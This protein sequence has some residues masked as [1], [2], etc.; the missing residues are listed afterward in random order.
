M[1]SNQDHHKIIEQLKQLPKI[2]DHTDKNDLYEQIRM[3]MNRSS[4]FTSIPKPTKKNKLIPLFSLALVVV[5]VLIM[6]PSFINQTS[7]QMSEKRSN[8]SIEL[9]DTQENGNTSSLNMQ[10]S[11]EE[12]LSKANQLD[13]HKQSYVLD[14]VGENRTI[15]YGAIVEEQ[16][17]FVIP[18]SL[19]LNEESDLSTAYNELH[20]YL[21][22]EEWGV[23]SDLFS[24]VTF[25]IDLSNEQVMLK[26]PA[27]FSLGDGSAKANIFLEMLTTM[28][29]Q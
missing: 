2:K 24:G 20:H 13:H 3:Q 6:L 25:D 4:E 27:G 11:S 9:F 26:L 19:I 12:L 17:Q 23:L 18:I 7:L 28:F 10:E 15:I 5:I 16:L 14:N 29:Q 21:K 22:E 8:E 1:N